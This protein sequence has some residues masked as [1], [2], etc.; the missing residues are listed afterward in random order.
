MK[1]IHPLQPI[2]LSELWEHEARNFTPWLANNM[3]LLG[4][5]LNLELEVVKVEARLPNAGQVDIL[6]QQ[7][8]TDTI[9]VIENQYGVSDDSHCLRLLGYAASADAGILVW[10]A[11]DFEDYHMKILSWLNRTD[12]IAVYAVKAE[13]TEPAT[14]SRTL[15][16]WSKLPIPVH[17]RP[18]LMA[19]L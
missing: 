19:V 8:G 13:A 14:P 15:S 3:M 10:V 18:R 5:E 17:L 9:V 16:G 6:A 11:E 1:E 4:A 12:T 2:R 7:V